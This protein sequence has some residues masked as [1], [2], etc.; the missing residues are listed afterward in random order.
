MPV[1]LGPDIEDVASSAYEAQVLQLPE[2][3]LAQPPFPVVP[4]TALGTPPAPVVKQEKVDSLRLA[5]LWHSGH[6]QGWSDWL[7]E[8]IFSN[9]VLHSGQTY[10][11]IGITVLLFLV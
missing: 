3:Q 8:R 11:Y 9:L 5:G 7:S 6:S 2:V 10:S 1:R 4:A